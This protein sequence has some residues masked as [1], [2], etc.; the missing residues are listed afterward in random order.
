MA[1]YAQITDGTII[2]TTGG[3]TAPGYGED[4]EWHDFS[5]P[6]VRDAYLTEHGWHV[7]TEVERPVDTDTHT[8]VLTYE[9]VAGQPTQVWTAR[10]WTPEEINAR[11]ER[12]VRLDDHEARIAAIEAHLWPADPD[13][14]PGAPTDAPTWGE[15]DPPGWWRPGTLLTDAGTTW[16][17][18]SGSV[19]TTPPSG[20]PG[21]PG[22][23]THLFVEV[24]TTDPEPDPDPT[25]PDGYVGP[26]SATATYAVGD[27]VDRAGRYYRCLVAHGAEYAGTWG[28]PNASVWTDLGPA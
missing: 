24:T 19:L 25:H 1:I 12:D 3:F 4:G 9:I 10:E 13:P 8:H 7:V 17:N 6:D 22:T 28:P 27:V 23:W 26:W 5:D 11:A 21:D 16:R 20:F 18:V 15:L 2:R 14:E